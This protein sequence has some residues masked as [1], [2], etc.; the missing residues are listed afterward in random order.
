MVG[1]K[2]APKAANSIEEMK[3]QLCFDLFDPADR[4]QLV[5]QCIASYNRRDFAEKVVSFVDLHNDDSVRDSL[6]WGIYAQTRWQRM[7]GR[8]SIDQDTGRVSITWWSA[9]NARLIAPL[10]L[11]LCAEHNKR[12]AISGLVVTDEMLNVWRDFARSPRDN[13]TYWRCHSAALN[14][15]AP[16]CSFLVNHMPLQEQLFAQGWILVAHD[17]AKID[18]VT[19]TRDLAI[20]N[21]SLFLPPFVLTEPNDV[22]KLSNQQ[23]RFVRRIQLRGQPQPKL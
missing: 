16:Q 23:Q 21:N 20:S 1:R 17:L 15:A 5:L 19:T 11:A 2:E 14:V 7:S 8:W 13:A 3:G 6:L 22:H 12:V 9:M 18:I 4:E 10:F